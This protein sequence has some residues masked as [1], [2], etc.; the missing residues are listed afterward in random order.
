MPV[1]IG[2]PSKPTIYRAALFFR[3][4]C[5]WS[6]FC[7]GREEARHAITGDS[8]RLAPAAAMHDRPAPCDTFARIPK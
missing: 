6:A 8:R 4:T 5:A 2:N 3:A 7:I 1:Q